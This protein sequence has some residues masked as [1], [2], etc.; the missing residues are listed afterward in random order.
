MA[1]VPGPVPEPVDA[2]GLAWTAAGALAGAPD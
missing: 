2:A 1:P